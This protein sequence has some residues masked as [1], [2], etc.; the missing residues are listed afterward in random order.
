[1]IQMQSM[2]N[3]AD[4]SG[5]RRLM[6]VKVLGGSRRR[7]AEIGDHVTED[8]LFEL[9]YGP[10]G[11]PTLFTLPVLRFMMETGTSEEQLAAVAVVQREWAG[12]N[13]RASYRDP[14]G[15][16]DVLGSRMIAY[17]F[18]LLMC[19]L[20][21]DGGGALILTSAE[22]ARDLP[23]KPVYVLGAGESVETPLVSQMED[24]TTSKAFRLSGRAAFAE[25]GLSNWEAHSNEVFVPSADLEVYLTAL[26]TANCGLGES[27]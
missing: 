13:P 22:R 2:L 5:A 17:P 3:A 21:T 8:L 18:R 25:A 1:M 6:C 7:Y 15:V 20:V 16:E 14:I 9:P 4:N 19:C 26:R 12:M 23:R 11:P 10:V 24:F 27:H